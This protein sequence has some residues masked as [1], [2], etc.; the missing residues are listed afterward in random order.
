MMNFNDLIG[1]EFK[2][3][4]VEFNHFKLDDTVFE[5]VEDEDDG[6]RSYLGSVEIFDK[7]G[8]IFFKE[9]LA[10][11]KIWEHDDGYRKVYKLLDVKDNHEWLVFGTE[12]YDDWYPFFVFTY[13]PKQA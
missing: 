1:K 8:L 3:Y 5:A 7:E 2:F 9:P 6:Y 11:I 4:G 13:T 10:T 12:N